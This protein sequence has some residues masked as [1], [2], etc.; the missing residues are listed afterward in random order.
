LGKT[1]R[2]IRTFFAYISEDSPLTKIN[3]VTKVIILLLINLYPLLIDN[4]VYNFIYGISLLSMMKIFKVEY[5]NV[6]KYFKVLMTLATFIFISVTFFGRSVA[7]PSPTVIARIGPIEVYKEAMAFGI[8]VYMRMFAMCSAMMFWL[9][10]T[11]TLE[12]SVALE[13]LGF[14][15]SLRTAIT[16]A[17]RYIGMFDTD[18]TIVQEAQ[19]ARGLDMKALPFYLRPILFGYYLIPL[20]AV[21]IRKAID[22]G[23]TMA[24]RGFK[25]SMKMKFIEEKA[26]R[27][28][29]TYLRKYHYK[30][31]TVPDYI[32]LAILAILLVVCLIGKFQGWLAN[33][34]YYTYII[35]TLIAW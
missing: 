25:G 11:T 20:T 6:G 21:V 14:S 19:K 8:M 4:P 3:P 23:T 1:V 17:F 34:W 5:K 10:S 29:I 28:K 26:A 27:A 31:L 24:A 15:Y 7:G 35:R 2:R 33:P 16:M 30:K 32:V 18:F 13:R 9:S 12:L 22:A